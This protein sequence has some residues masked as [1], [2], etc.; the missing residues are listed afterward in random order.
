MS[1]TLIDRCQGPVLSAG[2]T[3]GTMTA[4]RAVV[5]ERCN[6]GPD[7]IARRRR[8][9]IVMSVAT[10]AV[11][12]ALVAAHAP[13]W[14]RLLLWPLTAGTTVTWLQVVR[15]FCVRFGAF[16]LENF[17]RLGG[18]RKVDPSTRAGDARKAAEMILQGILVGLV[19]TSAFLWLP[20]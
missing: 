18:E 19:V 17:G 11:A 20:A 9:A 15:R 12:V 16:G 14:S 6:I 1:N 5:P 10:A 7:E 4:R 2:R 8:I 13:V 3:L